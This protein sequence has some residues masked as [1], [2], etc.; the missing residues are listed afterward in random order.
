MMNTFIVIKHHSE[1]RNQSIL[2]IHGDEEYIGK[3]TIALDNY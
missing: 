3:T 2:R 1:A